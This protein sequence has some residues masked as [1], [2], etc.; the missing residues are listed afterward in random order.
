MI[1]TD[2]RYATGSINYINDA[3]LNKNQLSVYRTFPS[4]ITKFLAYTWTSN[5][6]IDVLAAEFLG[7]SSLWWKIMDVNP[8]IANP[9][10]IEPGTVL[11][12]PSA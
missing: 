2:S 9:F 3:R 12:I 1:Y 5:D 10:S 6:R 4:V 8:E 7:S 11:R